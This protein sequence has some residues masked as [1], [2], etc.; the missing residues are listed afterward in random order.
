MTLKISLT[1]L[2]LLLLLSCQPQKSPDPQIQQETIKEAK[3]VNN[4]LAFG[5]EL[6]LPIIGAPDTFQTDFTVVRTFECKKQGC[7]KTAQLTLTLQNSNPAQ[8]FYVLDNFKEYSGQEIYPGRGRA[9]L[10]LTVDGIAYDSKDTIGRRIVDISHIGD[11]IQVSFD[12]VS[13]YSYNKKIFF[14]GKVMIASKPVKPIYKGHA[15]F[16]DGSADTVWYNIR[17][18]V[19]TY[20]FG[21]RDPERSSGVL[22]L[23]F[24]EPIQETKT[25]KVTY[26]TPTEGEVHVILCVQYVQC[27]NSSAINNTDG[28]LFVKKR[29]KG[30][31]SFDF[32]EIPSSG[33]F[34][35]TLYGSGVFSTFM[36]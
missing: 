33:L 15:V 1:Y 24:S 34:G 16:M 21:N 10:R 17:Y 35:R 13:L 4:E 18:G 7:N 19:H 23:E 8:G 27:Y 9:Q 11:S 36:P 12:S 20:Q 2:S 28:K 30:E 26:G 22:Q 32:E 25:Y 6:Y 3:L 31:F 14:S 29:A 5:E